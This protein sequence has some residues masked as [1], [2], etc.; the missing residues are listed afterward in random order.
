MLELINNQ[1]AYVFEHLMQDYEEEFSCITG[2]E[3]NQEG[4]YSIDTDWHFPNIGYY[5][6]EGSEVLGFC[7]KD[8]IDGYSDIA[9]FDNHPGLW[10]V[11]QLLEATLARKFWKQTLDDYTQGNYVELLITDPIWGEVTCQRFRST[12]HF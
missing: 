8:T 2:K 5:W 1:N 10:Q 4:T 12:P 9:V 11:R 6:K 7:I 3:K